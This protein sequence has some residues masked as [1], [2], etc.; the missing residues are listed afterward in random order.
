MTAI[1]RSWTSW[2]IFSSPVESSRTGE[3]FSALRSRFTADPEPY[4]ASDHE[5]KRIPSDCVNEVAVV[6]G[7]DGEATD[8]DHG[9]R[10]DNALRR[11]GALR[12]GRTLRGDR[13]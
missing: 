13:T 2:R 3:P 4:C 9:G 6:E 1:Q 11:G 7:D 5:C 10:G 8:G 12:G